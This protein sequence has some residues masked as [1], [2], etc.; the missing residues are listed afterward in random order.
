MSIFR[1]NRVVVVSQSNRNC[2][3]GLS[4][5]ETETQNGTTNHRKAVADP[6]A[7]PSTRTA[8][9]INRLTVD[10][11]DVRRDVADRTA[12]DERRD[13]VAGDGH[14]RQRGGRRQPERLVVAAGVV[15]DV[16]EVAEDE[17]HR[18]EPLKTRSRCPC[19]QAQTSTRHNHQPQLLLAN[20]TRPCCTVHAGTEDLLLYE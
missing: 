14:H 3:H 16:V 13:L 9:H 1:R 11:D 17:R 5:T 10:S 2:N 4:Q 6:K 12:T 8:W 18:A 15:A 19:V 20:W 7:T